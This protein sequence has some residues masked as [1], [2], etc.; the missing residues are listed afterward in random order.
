MKT[1]IEKVQSKMHYKEIL[2]SFQIKLKFWEILFKMKTFQ[3]Q[4]NK[5]NKNQMKLFQV[6]K[7]DVHV[8][9]LHVEKNIV[10]AI[11]KAFYVPIYVNVKVV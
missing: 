1:K 4:K 8:K 5:I 6:L 2:M 3:I 9:N 11:I 7:Q 10:N